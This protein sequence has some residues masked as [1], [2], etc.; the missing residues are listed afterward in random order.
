MD[1][2]VRASRTIDLF[3]PPP[4]CRCG[5][6]VQARGL[7]L[8]L[9]GS[10]DR[11]SRDHVHSVARRLID[12]GG[13]WHHR[14]EMNHVV[15]SD[16]R[17][18]HERLAADAPEAHVDLG[19]PAGV[20]LPARGCVEI[21]RPHRIASFE[22]GIDDVRADVPARAGDQDVCHEISSASCPSATRKALTV[23]S[24]SSSVCTAEMKNF[25]AALRTPCWRSK[26]EKRM[27]L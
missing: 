21:E 3:V 23:S 16:D 20:L 26:S 27:F 12:I 1:R 9:A 5:C 22:Q 17:I 8:S 25:S 2:L 11:S 10:D 7:W 13:R 6:E 18:T 19:T 14:C 15:D 4:N 24:M